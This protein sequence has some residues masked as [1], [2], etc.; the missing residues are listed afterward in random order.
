MVED[1]G[2]QKIIMV[3]LADLV[4]DVERELAEVLELQIK[5]LMVLVTLGLE[6]KVVEVVELVKIQAQVLE[7]EMV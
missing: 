2:V 6:T 1:L 4:E 3:E 5:V 7:V